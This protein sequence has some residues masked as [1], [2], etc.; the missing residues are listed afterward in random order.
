[1]PSSISFH[2]YSRNFNFSDWITLLTLCLAPL[3]AHIIA[4][5]RSPICL[6]SKKLH[7]HERIGHYNPTSI[8]WRYFAITDRR[9]RAKKWDYDE[10]A[11]SNALFWING[12]WDGSESMIGKTRNCCIRDAEKKH[13]RRIQLIS[14]STATTIVVTLQGIQAIYELVGGVTHR[15][16]LGVTIAI[17]NIF[18]PLAV[19]GLL[20]IPAALWLTDDYAYTTI[21]VGSTRGVETMIEVNVKTEVDTMTRALDAKD[22]IYQD[23]PFYPPHNWRGITIRALFLLLTIGLLAI[24]LLS[25][26]PWKVIPYSATTFSVSVFYII[27]ISM[28]TILLAMYN[29]LGKSTTTIIPCISSR[30]YK[31]YTC[32]VYFMMLTLITIAALETRRTPCGSYTTFDTQRDAYPILCSDSTYINGTNFPGAGMPYVNGSAVGVNVAESRIYNSFGLAAEVVNGLIVVQ[33]FV[34]WCKLTSYNNTVELFERV[35]QP[36]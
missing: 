34:G 29:L 23:S 12:E 14:G 5:V 4:G 30:W 11:A 8:I 28:T 18:F 36:S 21:E 31:I 24:S 20:R 35:G 27:F 26:S 15:I 16:D 3:I 25:L 33:S 10:M 1:M 32:V 19:I 6:D 22:N 17:N 9:A 13:L 7:W 2:D